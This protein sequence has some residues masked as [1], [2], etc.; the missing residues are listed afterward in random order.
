[1]PRAPSHS[2]ADRELSLFTF[3]FSF[4]SSA[5]VQMSA[6]SWEGHVT[7][8]ISRHQCMYMKMKLAVTVQLPTFK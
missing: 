3:R 6:V 8:N 4:Q 7:Q 1:M 2:G 5:R